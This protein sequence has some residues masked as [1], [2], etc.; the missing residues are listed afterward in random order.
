MARGVAPPFVEVLS[1]MRAGV[2]RNNPCAVDHLGR[3]DDVS[4]ALE[5][6][7]II[8]VDGG[9][10]GRRVGANNAAHGQGKIL[11]PLGQTRIE[12][13]VRRRARRPGALSFRRKRYGW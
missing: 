7:K 3:N 4:R 8:V 13:N 6:L 2:Q 10:V 12:T 1:K 9:K 11:N 5:N